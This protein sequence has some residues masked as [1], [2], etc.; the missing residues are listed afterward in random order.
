MDSPGE[1]FQNL[2]S[3][4]AGLRALDEKDVQIID[5]TRKE[6]IKRCEN[7]ESKKVV[8]YKQTTASEHPYCETIKEEGGSG[9]ES[10]SEKHN[11]N[12]IR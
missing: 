12:I 8:S 5:E 1:G 11:N 9:I 7:S 2:D 6:E 4:I 10:Y 3:A